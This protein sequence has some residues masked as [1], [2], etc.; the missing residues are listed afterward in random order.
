[1][2]GMERFTQRAR[3]VLSL[4]HQEAERRR[5]NVIGAE[6]LLLGLMDEEGGVAGRVL[7]EV[8]LTVEKVREVVRNVTN[9]SIDFNPDRVEIG[10]ETQKALEYAVEEARRL[11]H[12]YIGTEHILLGLVR[13]NSIAMEILDKLQINADMIRRQ[14][15]RVLNETATVS[16]TTSSDKVSKN[17]SQVFILHGQDEWKKTIAALVQTLGLVPV[18]LDEKN[19]DNMIVEYLDMYSKEIALAVIVLTNDDPRIMQ[20]DNKQPDWHVD[21]NLIYE[22]GYFRGKLGRNHTCVLYLDDFQNDVELLSV[23]MFMGVIFIPLDTGGSWMTQ[24]AKVIQDTGVETNLRN[25]L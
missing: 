25:K 14:T 15:R 10:L 24:L 2:A 7:R 11:G 3:R 23:F 18:L 12:N 4:A 17:F 21:H 16:S 6:H 19:V 5:N 13:I 8:G 20:S 22:L 9:A 1:M